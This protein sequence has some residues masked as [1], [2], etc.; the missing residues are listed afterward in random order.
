M[1]ELR[2]LNVKYEKYNEESSKEFCLPYGVIIKLFKWYLVAKC[3]LFKN[4]V[5]I[6]KCSRLKE[7][8][9]LDETFEIPKSFDLERFWQQS[10]TMF[11]KRLL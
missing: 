6:F 3:S 10:K 2:K 5:R 8:E 11:V 9:L 1:L 4:E 7:I